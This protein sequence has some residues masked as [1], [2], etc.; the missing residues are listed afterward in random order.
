MKILICSHAKLA[1]GMMSALRLIAG[2]KPQVQYLNAYLEGTD[3]RKDLNA[4]LDDS[5]EWLVLTDLA[6]GSVNQEVMQHLRTGKVHII[7]GMNLALVLALVLK[8]ENGGL[9][10]E[11]LRKAVEDSRSQI[12]YVNDQIKAAEDDFGNL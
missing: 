11:D 4:V 7:A 3:F 10:A 2:D 9:G 1:E 8:N 6:G 5:G 12:V